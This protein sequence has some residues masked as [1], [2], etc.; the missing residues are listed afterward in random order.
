[1]AGRGEPK[2]LDADVEDKRAADVEA[3]NVEDK[4]AADVEAVKGPMKRILKQLMTLAR[5]A[6]V[7]EEAAFMYNILC[8]QMSKIEITT[9]TVEQIMQLLE[10]EED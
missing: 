1:M 8:E 4:R 7:C 3:V 10:E 5:P 2:N 9:L 6:D